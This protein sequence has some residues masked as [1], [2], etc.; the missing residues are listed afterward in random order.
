[1][2]QNEIAE[3]VL[4]QARQLQKTVAD[5]VNQ[6]AEQMKPLL[7][8]SMNNAQELQKTLSEH[9]AQAT[10]QGQD[11]A[12]RAL[13]HLSEFMKIGADAMRANAEQARAMTQTLV[14]HTRK[15]VES[16]MNA[17]GGDKGKGT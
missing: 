11:Q 14:D 17:A 8:E 13:G 15:T 7:R 12:N 4:A 16:A 1:M 3:R 2:N 6:S 10:S 5:A 9:A